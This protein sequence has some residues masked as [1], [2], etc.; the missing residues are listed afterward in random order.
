LI[1]KA[2]NNKYAENGFCT[3]SR[4]NSNPTG[5]DC[6]YDFQ[7][8]HAKDL[9]DIGDYNN[10]VYGTGKYFDQLKQLNLNIQK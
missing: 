1:V 9:L 4:A 5:E 7:Y 8:Y 10:Y 6:I 2:N 3:I